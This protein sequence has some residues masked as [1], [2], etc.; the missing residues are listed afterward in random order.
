MAAGKHKLDNLIIVVDY[1][2]VQ[3][4]ERTAIVQDLEPLTSKWESFGFAVRNVDGHDVDG[5]Q[6]TFAALPFASGRPNAVIAHTIKGRGVAHAEGDPA[7][8]HKS[9]MSR[10]EINGVL[11]AIGD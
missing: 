7:W 5:L 10:A 9:N 11:R 1:N 2:K 8:H 4:Y 6:R 3:S